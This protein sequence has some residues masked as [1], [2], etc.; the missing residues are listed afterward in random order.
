L[1]RG[2]SGHDKG[3]V[4]A[5][6]P[7]HVSRGQ[8]S[9]G[10]VGKP[11]VWLS[12][13]KYDALVHAAQ[14]DCEPAVPLVQPEPV[15]ALKPPGVLVVDCPAGCGATLTVPIEVTDTPS[16]T[17]YDGELSVRYTAE[18]PELP[19]HIYKHL[20]TCTSARSWIDA[21]LHESI[22]SRPRRIS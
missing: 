4:M 22:A 5:I 13:A 19:E 21:A 7:R 9:C 18:A 6:R 11:H 16:V 1:I 14:C 8:C 15:T 2:D 3:L 10:W 20:R 17:S 12:A